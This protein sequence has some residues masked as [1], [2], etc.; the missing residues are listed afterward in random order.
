MQADPSWKPCSL[1]AALWRWNNDSSQSALVTFL[2]P[3]AYQTALLLNDVPVAGEP[4]RVLPSKETA[5]DHTISD[6]YPIRD[7]EDNQL[8][9]A[10]TVYGKASSAVSAAAKETV[11][12]CTMV[13]KYD[14]VITAFLLLSIA[15]HRLAN[16]AAEEWIKRRSLLMLNVK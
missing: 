16:H 7:T 12:I 15:I 3:F 1:T 14:P 2:Q 9:R 8:N 5:A 13:V 4:I 6:E 10:A 11:R